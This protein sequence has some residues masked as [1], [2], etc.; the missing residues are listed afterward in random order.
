MNLTQKIVDLKACLT[1]VL[2]CCTLCAGSLAHAA[3]PMITDDARI[4]DSKACQLESWRQRN[5]DS[6]EYW[7]LPA[8]NF[9]GNLELTLGGA[10]T[11]DDSG[12]HTSDIVIQGKTLLRPLEANGW[13]MALSFG[14]NRHPNMEKSGRD[15]YA[16]ALNSFSLRDDRFIIHTNI[17]WLHAQESRANRLTWGLGSETQLAAKTWLIA[18]TFGQDR[19][20]AFYQLGL[21]HWLLVDRVQIDV[22]YGNRMGGHSDG[23]WIS[24]GLRLLS[25]PFLP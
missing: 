1:W 2:A 19:G 20:S 13:G 9:T 25:P 22:T 12:T 8:C 4:T 10:S 5:R 11:H 21:R 14:A 15:W 6:T 18:E 3:R 24:V 16:N 7:L 17:G 23:R